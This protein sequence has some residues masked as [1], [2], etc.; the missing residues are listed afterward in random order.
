MAP[1]QARGEG[2]DHRTDL[3][4]L[5]LILYELLMNQPAYRVPTRSADPVAEVF[6]AIER[7]DLGTCVAELE[8]KMPGMGPVIARCLQARPANRYQNGQELLVDLR[9]QLYRERGDCLKEFCEFFFGQVFEIEELPSVEAVAA[10]TGRQAGQRLSMEERLRQSMDREKAARAVTPAVAPLLQPQPVGSSRPAPSQG[11]AIKTFVPN[12][13]PRAATP[14][15]SPPPPAP[16]SPSF[17]SPAPSA[18]PMAASAPRP[19][20]IGARTPDET[21]MVEI[22]PIHQLGAQQGSEDPSATSFFA[23]PAPKVEARAAT[24]PPRPPQPSPGSAPPMGGMAAPPAFQAAP[25][26]S[27]PAS[28]APV[29]AGPIAPEASSTPFQVQAQGMT[30]AATDS[31]QRAQSNRVYAII[32]GV[33]GLVGIAI[34][35]A[36]WAAPDKKGEETAPTK[37][38]VVLV[39]PPTTP[40]VEVPA[41]PVIPQQPPPRSSSNKGAPKGE[42]QPKATPPP[43]P[44]SSPGPLTVTLQDASGI[45]GVEVV[46]PSNF[47][48]RVSLAGNSAT[49]PNVPVESCTLFFKGAVNAQYGPVRGNQRLSCRLAGSTAVCQ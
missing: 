34:V 13:A 23:L 46:C 48:Q 12:A 32:L 5:G 20:V 37:Q 25:F 24:P 14:S 36:V 26:A 7:A 16:P 29:I 40:P 1:E 9:R 41:D 27:G 47:R 22:V 4:A 31:T 11:R 43:A 18:S 30:T 3:F 38:E 28:G 17:S 39:T 15:H 42:S 49:V 21:G 6:R 2:V 33:V 44:S 10:D 19:K 45:S 8:S 35:V